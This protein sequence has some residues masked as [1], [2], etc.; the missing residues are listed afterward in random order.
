MSSPFSFNPFWLQGLIQGYIYNV[1]MKEGSLFVLFV[2]LRSPKPS[3][4]S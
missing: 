4:K 2:M 1:S 3:L